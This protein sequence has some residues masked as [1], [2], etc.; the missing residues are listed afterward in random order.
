MR[1]NKHSE[2]NLYARLYFMICVRIYKTNEDENQAV[3]IPKLKLNI[4]D[5][6]IVNNNGITFMHPVLIL[7]QYSVIL[8]LFHMFNK[9]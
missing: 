9:S 4:L 3:K 7:I 1:K 6:F 8:E 5:V 2:N